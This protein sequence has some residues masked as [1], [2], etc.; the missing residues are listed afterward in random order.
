MLT[1]PP[2]LVLADP[3]GR[4]LIPGLLVKFVSHDA[5]VA[6]IGTSDT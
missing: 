6:D 2:S 4:R 5:I 1:Q 3:V